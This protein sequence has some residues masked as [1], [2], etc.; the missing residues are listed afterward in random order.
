[1]SSTEK[2]SVLRK[3][4]IVFLG[5]QSGK[6]SMQIILAS[7]LTATNTKQWAKHL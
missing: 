4:K 3:Y 5:D 1:M 6:Y 2:T 7:Y